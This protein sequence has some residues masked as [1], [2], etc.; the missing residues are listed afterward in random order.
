MD[1]CLTRR[2][3]GGVAG[4][5][6]STNDDVG[7]V[8]NVDDKRQRRQRLRK[9]RRTTKSKDANGR[10]VFPFFFSEIAGKSRVK[11]R[12]S[13]HSAP[14]AMLSLQR[15][16]KTL[17]GA[18]CLCTDAQGWAPL[19]PSHGAFAPSPQAA[20]A[21]GPLPSFAGRVGLKG[22]K[23]G[24]KSAVPSRPTPLSQLSQMLRKATIVV[25]R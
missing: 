11:L 1:N 13:P 6:R 21:A 15:L 23:R 22:A 4:C 12:V 3:N 10:F 7:D 2:T 16:T 9:K 14:C 24:N 20:L 25:L 17:D 18:Q 19:H 5:K 8:T